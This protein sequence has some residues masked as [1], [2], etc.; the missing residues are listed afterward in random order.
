VRGEH[1]AGLERLG[2]HFGRAG[3][4]QALDVAFIGG[5]DNDRY[6]R[7][8]GLD[9]EQDLFGERGVAEGDDHHAGSHQARGNQRILAPGIAE[10]DRFATGGRFANPVGIEVE[11]NVVDAL[12]TQK[13]RQVL[14]AATESA[15][16]RVLFGPHGLR[17]D[18]R[19]LHRAH[20]P[21]VGDEAHDQ[22]LAVVNDKRRGEHR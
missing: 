17:G 16:D 7:S 20:H 14:P 15:E 11:R 5:A 6:V 10:D 19:Q 4:R 22:L 8:H 18:R 3:A 1:Q 12:L 13:A 9:V 2:N 21:L